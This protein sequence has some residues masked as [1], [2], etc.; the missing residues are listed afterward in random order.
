MV[1]DEAKKR[2]VEEEVAM[3]RRDNM[4]VSVVMIAPQESVKLVLMKWVPVAVTNSNPSCA[5]HFLMQNAAELG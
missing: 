3:D 1:E 5:L 2:R 4:M